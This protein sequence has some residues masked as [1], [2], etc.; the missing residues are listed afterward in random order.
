VLIGLFT[1]L[2]ALGLFVFVLAATWLAHLYWAYPA[3]QQMI[4]YIMF[5]KNIGMAGG[6]LLLAGAGGGAWSVDG[7]L[8]R[9]SA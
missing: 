9:R 3:E 8:G 7:M 1:R 6:F 2:A 5:W 4:Q